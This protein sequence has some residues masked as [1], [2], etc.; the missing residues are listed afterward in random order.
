M[1]HKIQMTVAF[2]IVI[3]MPCML[4]CKKSQPGL[5]VTL[6]NKSVDSIMYYIKGRWRRTRIAGG[7]VG[8]SQTETRNSYIIFDDHKV[9]VG[10]DDGKYANTTIQWVRD[11]Y[12]SDSINTLNYFIKS[13]YLFFNLRYVVQSITDGELRLDQKVDDGN[14]YYYIR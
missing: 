11:R 7:A 3:V 9:V 8:P 14:S 4:S 10:D 6:Y 12:G 5:T 1:K 13:G 2:L